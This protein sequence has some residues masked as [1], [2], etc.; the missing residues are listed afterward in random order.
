MIIYG[1]NQLSLNFPFCFLCY[2]F[3]GFSLSTSSP[4]CIH[5]GEISCYTKQT[6][7]SGN[8][9]CDQKQ[10][11]DIHQEFLILVLA[12][13]YGLHQ[14]LTH[15]RRHTRRVSQFLMGEEPQSH[16]L[17]K[18]GQ[19]LQEYEQWFYRPKV[20]D[21][22]ASANLS[23]TCEL[24]SVRFSTVFCQRPQLGHSLEVNKQK[25]NVI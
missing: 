21:L 16:I 25:T 7:S 11:Y 10:P 14:L 22:F 19:P 6:C 24:C 1:P 9:S 17:E 8:P 4:T 20:L 12:Q 23:Q 5:M 18:R 3:L 2:L 13:L 15:V